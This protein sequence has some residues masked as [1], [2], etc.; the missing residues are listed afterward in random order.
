MQKTAAQIADEVFYKVALPKLFGKTKPKYVTQEEMSAAKDRTLRSLK[1]AGKTAPPKL[2]TER[3]SLS[4][5]PVWPHKKVA[6]ITNAIIVKLAQGGMQYEPTP[7]MDPSYYEDEPAKK[8]HWPWALGGAAVGGLGAHYAL[9]SQMVKDYR[10]TASGLGDAASASRAAYDAI[11]KNTITGKPMGWEGAASEPH[12]RRVLD[13]GAAGEN[14]NKLMPAHEAQK[15]FKGR[16]FAEAMPR[17]VLG[18]GLGLGAGL[19]A[20]SLF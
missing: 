6:Q 5:I 7:P 11:P 13:V 10:A 20:S 9:P 1:P 18:A 2:P 19:L 12:M 4:E 15:Y 8:R 16:A 14:V 17:S 3:M